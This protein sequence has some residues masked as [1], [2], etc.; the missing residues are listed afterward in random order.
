MSERPEEALEWLRAEEKRYREDRRPKDPPYPY[1]HLE[2]IGAYIIELEGEN[3][4]LGKLDREL[5]EGDVESIT[6]EAYQST[7]KRFTQIRIQRWSL[8]DI[9]ADDLAAAIDQLEEAP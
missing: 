7:P 6:P 3:E 1:F 5:L 9:V 2:K 4:R 8:P